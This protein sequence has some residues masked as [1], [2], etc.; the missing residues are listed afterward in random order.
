MYN[1]GNSKVFTPQTHTEN[2]FQTMISDMNET[3][4]RQRTRITIT[5]YYQSQVSKTLASPY[6][7]YSA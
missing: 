7:V 6:K 2:Y 3:A 1:G 5:V 4:I